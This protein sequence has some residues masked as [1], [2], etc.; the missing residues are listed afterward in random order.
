MIQCSQCQYCHRS[1][2][3]ELVFSCNPF[4]N[5]VEPECLL[6][7]QLLK[8]DAMVRAYQATMAQYRRL[9]PLQEKMFKMMERELEDM[10]EA[11]KWKYEDDD[12]DEPPEQEPDEPEFPFGAPR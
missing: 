4:S 6:K 11:E 8:L 10:D 12:E 5:I 9:A 7:W 3:G 2:T 1:E